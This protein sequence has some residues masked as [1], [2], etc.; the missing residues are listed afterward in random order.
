MVRLSTHARTRCQ[1]RAVKPE[2]LALVLDNADIEVPVGSNCTLL[3]VHRRTA[4]RLNA[5]DRLHRY[6][7]VVNGCTGE[8]VTVLPIERG[9]RGARYR[10]RGR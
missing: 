10:R 9:R 7:V 3:R 5:G 4:R 1:Q 2:F 6:G 8:V